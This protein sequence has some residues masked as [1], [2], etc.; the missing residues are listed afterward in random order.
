MHLVLEPRARRGNA[1]RMV[2]ALR[3]TLLGLATVAALAA[4]EEVYRW[5]DEQ[6]EVHYTNDRSTIPEKFRKKA[7]PVKG[8]ELFTVTPSQEGPSRTRAPEASADQGAPAQAPDEES[9]RRQFR[10]AHQHI[11]DLE[12]QIAEDRQMLDGGAL[13]PKLTQGVMKMDPRFGET[14][15]RIQKNEQELARAREALDDLERKASQEAVPW[16]WRR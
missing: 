16:D 6:G 14:Q 13:A 9:W 12:K 3:L 1:P 10:E 11:A 4:A 5:T 7:E 8:G 15:E 2:R